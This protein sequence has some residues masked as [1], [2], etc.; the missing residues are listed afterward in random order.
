MSNRQPVSLQAIAITDDAAVRKPLRKGV[1]G[2]QIDL[3]FVDGTAGAVKIQ[4]Q[5]IDAIII[6][7]ESSPQADELIEK[8]RCS[9]TNNGSAIFVVTISNIKGARAL[10]LGANMIIQK[11]VSA[12]A[13][14]LCFEASY[15]RMIQ[16]R[17]R[18][19]RYPVLL[20]GLAEL[21]GERHEI[22][23][24]N[25]SDTGLAIATETSVQPG[26]TLLIRYFIPDIR[27]DVECEA[28]AAW[29][30][31]GRIGLKLTRIDPLIAKELKD[32]LGQV[33]H[34]QLASLG[35]TVG[36]HAIVDSVT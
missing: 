15:N 28:A 23:V 21:S 13:V 35:P 6:D 24:V 19:F 3:E 11:P 31:G 25:I 20:T 18:F 9:P 12:E 33:F 16:E 32:W 5:R 29:C 7:L 36:Q 1:G 26:T 10:E 8:V 27:L 17:R 2:S 22:T 4:T 34:E 14:R 30:A